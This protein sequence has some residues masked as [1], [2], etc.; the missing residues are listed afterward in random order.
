MNIQ[1]ISMEQQNIEKRNT[2][3]NTFIQRKQCSV[4]SS[5][6]QPPSEQRSIKIIL[7]TSFLVPPTLIYTNYI[8]KECSRGR[9]F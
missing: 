2:I 9:S 7:K 3:N 8:F 1:Q 5:R 6:G 4:A